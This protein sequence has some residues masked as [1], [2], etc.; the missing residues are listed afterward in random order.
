MLTRKFFTFNEVQKKMCTTKNVDN[1]EN[2][3]DHFDTVFFLFSDFIKQVPNNVTCVL[4]KWKYSNN[5]FLLRQLLKA[6][7]ENS[8]LLLSFVFDLWEFWFLFIKIS[9]RDD[10]L[11]REILTGKYKSLNNETIYVL[12]TN[13]P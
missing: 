8:F 4:L 11:K 9:A 13:C 5:F 1:I 10:Y 3:F 6:S 7:I 12:S 2:K